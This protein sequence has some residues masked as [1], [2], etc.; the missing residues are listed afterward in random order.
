MRK[1]S[2]KPEDLVEKS[3]MALNAAMATITGMAQ[4][5]AADLKELKGP[6]QVEIGFG[7]KLDAEAGAIIAKAGAEGSISVKLTWQNK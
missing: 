1:V 3:A 7:L 6:S 4:K 2:L 5:V